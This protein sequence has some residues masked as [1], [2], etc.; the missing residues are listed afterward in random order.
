MGAMLWSQMGAMLPLVSY[1][2]IPASMFRNLRESQE[3]MGKMAGCRK[4]FFL[5]PAV[6]RKENRQANDLQ[7]GDNAGRGLL[8]VGRLARSGSDQQGSTEIGSKIPLQPSR[9]SGE[10]VCS[11]ASGCLCAPRGVNLKRGGFPPQEHNV[12][13]VP[14]TA[15]SRS[16]GRSNQVAQPVHRGSTARLGQEREEGKNCH[17]CPLRR[18]P[19]RGI[20]KPQHHSFWKWETPVITMSNIL[21]NQAPTILGALTTTFIPPPEC[22]AAIGVLSTGFLGLGKSALNIANLG[23]TCSKGEGKEATTCWPPTSSGAPSKS[24]PGW[25]IYSPGIECPSGYVTACSAV[26]GR[27]GKAGWNMQFRLGAEETAVGCCPR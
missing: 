4:S 7:G 25:G 22:T 1:P 6:S 9:H 19:S 23:Q 11:V 2:G 8:S 17:G 15:I 27:D 24:A 21:V 13:W 16:L 12:T 3:K 20:H 10:P 18:C 26:G 5:P 14:V